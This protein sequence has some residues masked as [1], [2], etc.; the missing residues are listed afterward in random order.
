MAY[1][2]SWAGGKVERAVRDVV[3]LADGIPLC[4][5]DCRPLFEP[6]AAAARLHLGIHPANFAKIAT[7]AQL[8]AVLRGPSLVLGDMLRE[9]QHAAPG[10]HRELAIAFMCKSGRHRSIACA[11]IGA[12]IAGTCLRSRMCV[13]TNATPVSRTDAHCTDCD[14]CEFFSR[15]NP[16]REDVLKAACRV[17]QA[18]WQPR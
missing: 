8:G 12:E 15:A 5:V 18:Q 10:D 16:F 14:Q 6:T 17:W 3:Q 1:T 11:R 9:V 13:L 4:V 7:H 2:N